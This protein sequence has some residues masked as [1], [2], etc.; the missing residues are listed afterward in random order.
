MK[1]KHH[2]ISRILCI[3]Y[4]AAAARDGNPARG[5]ASSQRPSTSN[6][7]LC[8]ADDLPEMGFGIGFLQR[9]TNGS[10]MRTGEGG[11]T[12]TLQMWWGI[13]RSSPGEIGRDDGGRF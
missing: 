7:R 11:I 6:E 13:V 1:G 5:I 10:V 3:L 12:F 4:H 2:T 9:A 8:A